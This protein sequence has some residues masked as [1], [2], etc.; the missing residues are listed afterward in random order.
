MVD[1]NLTLDSVHFTAVVN[2]AKSFEIR[3]YD[4]KRK[5]MD[6]GDTIAFKNKDTGATTTKI[7]VSLDHC[8][9]FQRAIEKAT[10]ACCLP[11]VENVKTIEDAVDFY[12]NIGD[13]YYDRMEEKF[14]VVLI[15]LG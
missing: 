6:V 8:K 4:E 10:V 3:L 14:G 2:N 9:T 15:G 7:I 11:N 1:H 12:K 13:G 5:L